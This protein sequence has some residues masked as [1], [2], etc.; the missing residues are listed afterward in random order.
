VDSSRSSDIAGTGL[1]LSI[2]KHIIQKHEGRI[3]AH[4]TPETGTSFSLSFPSAH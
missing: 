2:V 1:G 3:K 4:S